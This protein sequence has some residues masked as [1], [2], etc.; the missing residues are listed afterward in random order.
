MLR[1][2]AI[3][4]VV[5]LA[6]GCA[7][8]RQAPAPL[9]EPGPVEELTRLIE[10]GCYRCLESAFAEA[11]ARGVRAHAFEAAALLVLRSKELGLPFEAWLE[12]ARA[13]AGSD[14]SSS[15][16]LDIVTAIPPFPLSGNRDAMVDLTARVQA[17][18]SLTSW[19]EALQGPPP[20]ESGGGASDV[21][22]A[23]LDVSLVCAFGRLRQD[24]QSFSEPLDPVARVPLYQYGIGICD[25][26]QAARLAALRAG[27]PEFVDADFALGRYALEDTVHPDPEQAIRHLES[28]A[29]AFPRSPAITTMIGDVYRAWE[30]WAPALAAY[31][32]AIAASPDHPEALLGRTISLSRLLR[33]QEAIATAT[34]LIDLGQWRVGEAHYWR[35]WNYLLAGEYQIARRDADSARAL[36]ANAALFVLSGTIEWRLRRLET[37]EQE[38]QEA[39]TMDLGECEAAF[40]LGVVRDERGKPPEALAAFQ[41]ARQCHD[42]STKLRRE[43]IATIWAG[44]GTETAKARAAAVHERVLAD[45][46]E[47]HEAAVKAIDVLEKLRTSQ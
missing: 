36:M 41:Q 8:R 26:T 45:L 20:A 9:G 14:G 40:D 22:R 27:D 35:A 25:N 12:K 37:A 3:L 5:V 21:F 43:A 15:L 23:Y 2:V 18:A 16:S 33:S 13:H 4:A 44:A 29:D 42:L 32:D 47:Q 30:E 1:I 6:A 28:A 38:F 19:R 11:E 10:H 7:A 46:E 17:R 31:D 24:E 39:L 34:R